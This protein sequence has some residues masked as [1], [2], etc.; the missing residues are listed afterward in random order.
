MARPAFLGTAALVNIAAS[1][2][3][4]GA[5]ESVACLAVLDLTISDLVDTS[6][7]DLS[8]S[9]LV[10]TSTA[11]LNLSVSDLVDTSTAVLDLAV[12]NLVGVVATVLDL[13]ISDLVNT[14][15]VLDLSVSDLVNTTASVLDLA[16]T[17]LHGSG[18]SW[19]RWDLELSISDLGDTV[20]DLTIGNLV[21]GS[22][23]HAR[24][25][26]GAR[27]HAVSETGSSTVHAHS[28]AVTW[29][30]LNVNWSA[31]LSN[32]LVVDIEE[33]ARGT[34]VEDGAVTESQVAGWLADGPAS[35]VDGTGLGWWAIELELA[36]GDDGANAA[37]SISEDAIVEVGNKSALTSALV[38]EDVS[39]SRKEAGGYEQTRPDGEQWLA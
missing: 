11:V 25:H 9:D 20:L 16:I 15:A 5:A 19:L 13:A 39:Q 32:W 35:S 7:L 30:S 1:V 14:T 22:G 31:L 2:I 3:S 36:V 37:L 27:G 33:V 18:G 23:G 4:V 29:D 8:I 24:A 10:N 6:V 38:L 12:G 21:S 34:L 17:N 28:R 26:V